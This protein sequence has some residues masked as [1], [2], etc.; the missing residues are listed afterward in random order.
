H[1]V[2]EALVK[3]AERAYPKLPEML[4]LNSG[5]QPEE[6]V[7]R[8]KRFFDGVEDPLAVQVL[9]SRIVNTSLKM[10]GEE[11]QTMLLKLLEEGNTCQA[12]QQ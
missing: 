11:W 2:S 3:A 10:L 9:L 5:L 12:S 8:L 7:S 4:G 1:P 6:I